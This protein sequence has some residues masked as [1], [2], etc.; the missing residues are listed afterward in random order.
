MALQPNYDTLLK[1]QQQ[2]IDDAAILAGEE[3]GPSDASW[4]DVAGTMATNLRVYA[5][6]LDRA[7]EGTYGHCSFPSWSE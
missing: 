1:L 5:R 6:L 7:R 4:Q 3:L 2:I